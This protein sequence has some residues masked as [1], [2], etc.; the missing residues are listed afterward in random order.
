M[1]E[2]EPLNTLTTAKVLGKFVSTQ[3]QRVSVTFG[4]RSSNGQ[5]DAVVWLILTYL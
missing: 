3:A 4:Q 1:Q 5:N 2:Q